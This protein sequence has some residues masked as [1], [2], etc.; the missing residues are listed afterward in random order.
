MNMANNV[1]KS[2]PWQGTFLGVLDVIGVVI[3]VLF[4]ILF[5]FLQ[6]VLTSVFNSANY[7]AVTTTTANG[8][9]AAGG[10]MAL[11]SGFSYAIGFVLL[12]SAIL[13]IFLARGAFKGQKWSPIVSIICAVLGV[14]GSVANYNN[15]NLIGLILNLF[16]VYLGVMCVKNSYYA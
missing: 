11:I 3:A 15:S 14:L 12:G 10:F 9:V 6:G 13:G 1:G 5:L 4:S 16:V 7:A 8:A 2:R